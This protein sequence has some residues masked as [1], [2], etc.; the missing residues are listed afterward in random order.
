RM[1]LQPAE[2]LVDEVDRHGAF[3]GCRGDALHRAMADV[4]GDKDSRNAGLE[5]ERLAPY[6]PAL[7][8]MPRLAEIW[9]GQQISLRVDRDQVGDPV[10][11]RHGADEDE[12]RIGRD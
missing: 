1:A 12:E 8:D 10:G 5:P 11:L 2:I 7:W 3:T 4:S 6:R 9:P